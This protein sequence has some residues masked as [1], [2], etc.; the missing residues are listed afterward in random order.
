MFSSLQKND[1]PTVALVQH[2]H[3][4]GWARLHAHADGLAELVVAAAFLPGHA[5]RAHVLALPDLL[6]R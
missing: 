6:A 1:D 3:A 5:E 2:E 4:A